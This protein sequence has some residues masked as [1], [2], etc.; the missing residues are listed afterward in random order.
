MTTPLLFYQGA[1]IMIT[2]W[3][4]AFIVPVLMVVSGILHFPKYRSRQ[5]LSE[6]QQQFAN[7]LAW[8]MR[9][10]F[11]LVFAA[12]AFMLMRSV[13]RMAAGTQQMIVYVV[14]VL[15]VIGLWL[16]VLPVERALQENSDEMT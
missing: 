6:K 13:L 1:E 9:W 10:Q 8:K 15:Q 3:W 2:I 11:G 5:K 12:L 4:P 14:I 7:G 16:I